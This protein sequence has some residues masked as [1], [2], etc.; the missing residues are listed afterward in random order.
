MLA[1]RIPVF[2]R[3][4]ADVAAIGIYVWI[5]SV[6][7]HGGRWFRGLAL[8]MLGW[9][10]I[11]VFLLSFFLRDGRRSRISTLAMCIGAVGI[12][13]LGVE[14]CLDRYF[15]GAWQPSWSLAVLVICIGL[16]IPL[17]IGAPWFRPSG[18]KRAGASICEQTLLK[19]K[20]RPD[21]FRSAFF[22]W[23]NQLFAIL[24]RRRAIF[25]CGASMASPCI[26]LQSV[27]MSSM[28][29]S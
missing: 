18:R 5:I 28:T 6:A 29:F 25:L 9:A 12:L 8:P 22:L 21:T 15:L 7:L 1:R 2:F 26:S 20:K 19:W 16:I 4:T 24:S 23:K 27:R 11:V 14:Y 3:L 10:C 17:R 13:A